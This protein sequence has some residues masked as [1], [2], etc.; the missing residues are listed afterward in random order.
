MEVYLCYGLVKGVQF[1]WVGGVV[2]M[3]FGYKCAF[4]WHPGV[5]TELPCC[6]RT[7]LSSPSRVLTTYE[8]MISILVSTTK[9]LIDISLLIL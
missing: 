3:F 5:Y 8:I 4:V 7:V 9:N 6:D 2:D 1:H